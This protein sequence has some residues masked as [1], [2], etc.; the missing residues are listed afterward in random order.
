MNQQLEKDLK[1][2]M[3]IISSKWK[4]QNNSFDRSTNFIYQ[5]KSLEDC[6]IEIKRTRVDR[7]YVLHRWY[8]LYDI[9]IL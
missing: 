3:D 2:N 6:M 8:N 1:D 9:N 4:M 7:D 5:M